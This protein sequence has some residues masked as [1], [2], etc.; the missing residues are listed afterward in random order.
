MEINEKIEEFLD[1]KNGVKDKND[2]YIFDCECKNDAQSCKGKGVLFKNNLYHWYCSHNSKGFETGIEY[3]E[4]ENDG[5]RKQK[6]ESYINHGIDITKLIHAKVIDSNTLN[7]VTSNNKYLWCDD[8]RKKC[9]WKNKAGSKKKIT[10]EIH[11]IFQ[12]K[13][14]QRLYIFSGEWD[15]LKAIQDNLTCTSPMYGE[16][17]KLQ[18]KETLSKFA[19]FNEIVFCYDC[20][21]AGID[22]MKK[23]ISFLKSNLK[24]KIGHIEL[25]SPSTHTQKGNKDYCDYRINSNI[26]DFLSIKINW[27]SETTLAAPK[28]TTPKTKP[29]ANKSKFI[30][31]GTET[32]R[33]YYIKK[34]DD[35]ERVCEIYANFTIRIISEVTD[36]KDES[37]MIIE[38]KS[39]RK[40][41][42]IALESGDELTLPG[43]FASRIGKNG[44]FMVYTPSSK[45]QCV[46]NDF[47]EYV[48][49]VSNIG[50]KRKTNYIGRIS[51]KAYLFNNAIVTK[52]GKSDKLKDIIAPNGAKTRYGFNDKVNWEKILSDFEKLYSKEIWKLFGFACATLHYEKVV[53]RFHRLPL[54]FL[55]G[56]RGTGKSNLAT[57][58]CSMFGVM[59]ENAYNV[60]STAKGIW[61]EAE[62]CKGMPI[63]LNEYKGSQR[64]NQFLSQIYDREGYL[65][66]QKSNDLE[67]IKTEVNSGFIVIST[68]KVSG[69]EASAV[70]SRMITLETDSLTRNQETLE[71]YSKLY[72]ERQKLTSFINIAIKLDINKILEDVSKCA[73]E[74]MK[75]NN[76][77]GRTAENHAIFYCFAQAFFKEC[78]FTIEDKETISRSIEANK[79]ESEWHDDGRIFL[80]LLIAEMGKGDYGTIPKNA[81]KIKTSNGL[82]FYLADV[83]EN[84]VPGDTEIVFNISA[85]LGYVKKLEGGK[86]LPDVRTLGKRMQSLGLKQQRS[87]NNRKWVG[88]ANII[89]QFV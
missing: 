23:N 5:Y 65:R 35:Y 86:D 62:K 84:G 36:D 83:L 10:G 53:D 50:Q 12:G 55:N 74:Y 77:D 70:A 27:N 48:F 1:T 72:S 58:L 73:C 19:K 30:E 6:T 87:A 9:V 85:C 28:E 79:H 7:I 17:A 45:A 69:Y 34:K 57:L 68:R 75:E 29:I 67:T 37:T 76:C 63:T 46:H 54:L 66:A 4:H 81:A 38:L 80:Q 8:S 24:S 82:G 42:K 88:D 60:A 15:Y 31:I 32:Y 56:E 21:Q 41:K 18:S 2:K 47:I 40:T 59:K 61:R 43:K 39:K 64:A 71:L 51:D 13:N 89:R 52:D 20:D 25:F 14:T 33:E 44:A 26:Q 22:G 49:S 3:T 11:D 78:G 16:S